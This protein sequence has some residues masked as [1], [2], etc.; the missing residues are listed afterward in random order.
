MKT[1]VTT[2]LLATAAMAAT[3]PQSPGHPFNPSRIVASADSFVVVT[4]VTGGDW[5]VI[6]GVVQ[7]VARDTNAIRMALDASFMGSKHRIEM[8]MHPTTL[9]PLAHW[10]KISRRG[11]GDANGE[12]MFSDGRVRGAYILSKGIIDL[13]LENGIVDE[14]AATMLLATLPLDSARS[15][16]FRTFASPGKVETTRV[17]VAGVDTVTVPAGRF[18]TKRLVVMAR[19]TSHVFVSTTPPHRV[20]LVRLANGSTEMLLIN[21]SR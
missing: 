9:A 2:L 4:R 15:F 18:V 11:Q 7:T 8:A 6:G 21:G 19:D 14:D 1:F 12:L 10:E 17:D 16:T 3:A 5:R 20:V 13:P